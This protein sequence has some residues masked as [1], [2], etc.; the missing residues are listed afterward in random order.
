MGEII[1]FKNEIEDLQVEY[2]VLSPIDFKHMNDPKQLEIIEKLET[3]DDML[4]EN[5]KIIDEINSE[6]D[7]LTN[8][9][10]GLDYKVAVA[11]GVVTGLI[12]VFLVG[13]FDFAGSKEVIDKKFDE[14]V[15]KKARDI[16]EKEKDQ[17]IK[18]AIENAQ[19]KANEKG[20]K[21]SDDKIRQ[22]KDS[23]NDKFKKDHDM[24]AKLKK[25]IEEAKQK[26]EAI[27]DAKI[28]ELKEKL[29]NSEM[30]KAI[31]K[32]EQTF[33][34]PSDDVYNVA[35][36][37]ISSKSHHLDDLAHHPTVIGWAASMVTQFTGNAYFQNKDGENMKYA[38]QRVRVLDNVNAYIQYGDTSVI[39]KTIKTGKTKQALQVTL[40]G[41]DLKS[42]LACGTINWIGHLLSD[43]AGSNSSAKKGNTGM[44][45]PG[46]LLSSLKEF[47]MLPIIK[48]TPLPQLLNDLFTKDDAILG[49]YRMDLRSELAIGKELGKQAI[50]IFINT[51]M[52]RIFYFIRRFIAE[53]KMANSLHDINWEN[54]LPFKNRTVTRMLTISLG[55]FEAIDLGD[56]TI[57]GVMNSGGTLAG[58]FASFVLRVNFVGVGRFAIACGTDISMGVGREK[59]RNERIKLYNEQIYLLEAKVYY[60]EA[61]MWVSAESAVEATNELCEYVDDM[62]PKLIESNKV[63]MNGLENLQGSV[64]V[65]AK[66]NP[67]WAAQMRRRLRR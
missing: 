21:L 9:A 33:G 28:K 55:T 37:Q 7:R 39:D 10:D 58:F 64:P 5:Q 4:T 62:I 14:I 54:T 15:Q 26:G 48:K 50:P 22:I 66:N 61:G 67:E 60:R 35:G 42:K 38:A 23:I 27:D 53:A 45:L 18:K 36:N 32:L 49:K 46:P 8:H 47:A 59:Q 57:R 31:K 3:V 19:K 16:E 65:V 29:D 24:D 25:A 6:I 44:G 13:E 52:V 51:L 63:V 2:Q 17:K 30:S 20:K 41:D 12:D 40:I 56:A 11:C 43:M 1:Q 34:M